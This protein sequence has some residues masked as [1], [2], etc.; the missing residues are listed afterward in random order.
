MVVDDQDGSPI[1]DVDV[2]VHNGWEVLFPGHTGP[3]GRFRISGVKPGTY[4]LAARKRGYV[5]YWVEPPIKFDVRSDGTIELAPIRLTATAAISGMVFDPWGDPIKGAD[6]SLATSSQLLSATGIR[7]YRTATDD[8]GGFTFPEVKPNRY[9][10][11][12]RATNRYGGTF[13]VQS[14]ASNG[15]IEWREATYSTSYWKA[16]E[17]TVQWSEISVGSKGK[18]GN[19]R[20]QLGWSIGAQMRPD[21]EFGDHHLRVQTIDRTTR[22]PVP[23]AQLAIWP[24]PAIR[25][26]RT[27]VRI[28]TT[29]SDESGMVSFSGLATGEYEVYVER[30]GYSDA[31][32]KVR[33]TA[34]LG[35]PALL[36]IVPADAAP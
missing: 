32:F 33:S 17:T 8:H 35:D 15:S 13:V 2:G 21:I 9:I 31:S 1:D 4:F 22:K 27:R 19:L 26:G 11:V 14:S 7:M 3:D 18:L 12:A 25:A 29:L 24:L 6:V 28:I 16:P 36:E 23:H 30:I 34:R 20:L 10:V 5:T